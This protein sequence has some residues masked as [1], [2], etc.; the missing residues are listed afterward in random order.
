MSKRARSNNSRRAP[1]PIDK[2]LKAI[3][4]TT[5]NAA[6]DATTLITAT[7][8]GTITGLRWVLD[9]SNA[10]G[11]NGCEY[12][13]AIVHTKDGND[14]NDFATS[15]AADFYAPEQ[16]VLAFGL[17][18]LGVTTNGESIAS[19]EGSTKTMRKLKQGDEIL[20]LVKNLGSGTSLKTSGVVQFFN[21][22]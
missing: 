1:R 5:A 8:P 16:N 9:F 20:F 4:I 10:D 22:T 17:G 3:K 6:Q 7:F 21:K 19:V 12:C 13:W 18:T 2:Q 15:D 11:A 14:A